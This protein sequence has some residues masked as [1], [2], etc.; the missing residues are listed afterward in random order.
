MDFEQQLDLAFEGEFLV[1]RINQQAYRDIYTLEGWLRRLCLASWMRAYGAL[2]QER[3]DP[4]LRKNLERL[5]EKSR[6]R[7]HLAA[8]TSE[9]LI[10]QS[11]IGQLLSMLADP[12]IA[13]DVH[14]LAGQDQQEIT[15]DFQEIRE[16]RNVLAHNRALSPETYAILRGSIIRLQKIVD[17]FRSCLLYSTS[18]I[19]DDDDGDLGSYLAMLLEGNDWSSFQAFVARGNGFIEYVTLPTSPFEKWPD[20]RR[21]LDVFSDHLECITAFTMN[22]LGSEFIIVAPEELDE[23]SQA[24]LCRVFAANPNIWTDVPCEKQHPRFICSPKMWIY[25]NQSPFR[26]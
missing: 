14:H 24:D 11:D 18:N 4:K 12:Q 7:L 21:L 22:R 16:I 26:S 5:A 8:E 6:Q 10:W 20:A 19:L 9:D 17:H 13:D 2:W 23:D 1:P 3:L 15:K 25:E